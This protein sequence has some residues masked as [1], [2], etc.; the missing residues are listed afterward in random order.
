MIF[1]DKI[2]QLRK[3]KNWSQEDLASQLGASRQSISKWGTETKRKIHKVSLED[4][5]LFLKAQRKYAFNLMIGVVLCILGFSSVVCI[6][7]LAQQRVL[8]LSLE[9]GEALGAASLFILVA[10]AV[11]VFVTSH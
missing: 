11:V 6:S 2:I 7:T 10:I 1:A 5:D 4:A 3:E 9:A 8:P